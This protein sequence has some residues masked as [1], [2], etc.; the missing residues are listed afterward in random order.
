MSDFV[1]QGTC[2]ARPHGW[3]AILADVLCYLLG[4]NLWRSMN[5]SVSPVGGTLDVYG[6]HCR[7][8]WV[9]GYV[10]GD[11]RPQLTRPTAPTHTRPVMPEHTRAGTVDDRATRPPKR[12]K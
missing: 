7:R 4:H 2:I 1:Q 8:C 9:Y 6:T 10:E 5:T 12:R 3:R 11:Y